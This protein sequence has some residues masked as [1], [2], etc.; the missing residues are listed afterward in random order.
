MGTGVGW[1]DAGRGDEGDGR[2]VAHCTLR[3]SWLW[4]L[5]TIFDAVA[6]RIGGIAERTRGGEHDG[7]L[8]AGPS[9]I[10]RTLKKREVP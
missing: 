8:R 9:V 3:V 2:D 1:T 5:H 7:L 6:S 10:R 4:R